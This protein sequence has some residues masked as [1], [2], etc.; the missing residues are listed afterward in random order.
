MKSILL[1]I[2]KDWCVFALATL[3]IHYINVITL[4]TDTVLLNFNFSFFSK[5]LYKIHRYISTS[6]FHLFFPPNV[7]G[8]YQ[9]EGFDL[10]YQFE[11]Q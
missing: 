8:K 9:L 2:N 5:L 1:D 3:E 4:Y 11:M 7:R 6:G 10:C